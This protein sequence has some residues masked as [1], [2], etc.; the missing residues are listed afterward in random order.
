MTWSERWTSWAYRRMTTAR[1]REQLDR[2]ELRDAGHG[3]D[4]LGAHPQSVR[5]AIASLT[6]LYE[7]Y[8]R[9][10][11][12]GAEHIPKSGP[13]ILACNHS[14]LLPID[15]MMLT[16]DV[17]RRTDPPRLPRNV[18]DRFLPKVPFAGTNFTR[19]GMVAGSRSNFRRMLEQGELLCVFPEGV[20]GIGKGY[21]KRYQL[22]EFRPGHAELALE[23]R[24]PVIPVG[25][26]GAEEAWPQ[27]A[28]IE[29]FGAFGAPY[30]PIP[31]TP[32]P[33]PVR[34]HINYGQPLLLHEVFDSDQ[35]LDPDVAQLAAARVRSAVEELVAKGLDERDGV[36]T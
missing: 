32:L 4:E 23:L 30:L 29:G 34:F 9:V 19:V 7:H 3:Y 13:A 36:F 6:P 28:R 35:A 22:E 2:L 5:L 8:F 16:V 14:G 18:G 10:R 31:A 17:V 27:I 24:V 26:V 33:M 25:L 21:A 1:Q 11:S 12:R 20:P 15:S